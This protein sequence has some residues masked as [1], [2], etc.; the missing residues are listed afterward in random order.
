MENEKKTTETKVRGTTKSTAKK[1][2][3][4]KKDNKTVETPMET[5]VAMNEEINE[6][7]MSENQTLEQEQATP[8]GFTPE[9]MQQMFM[10]FQQMQQMS[11]Q[12]Q[13]STSVD[14][15]V[16]IKVDRN[17]KFT[18]SMLSK[19]E[20]EEVVVRS[21][22]NNRIFISPRTSIK[23]R[24]ESKGDVETLKIKEIL[25]MENTSKR[26]LHTPWLIVE[27]DRVAEALG[28]KE[29]YDMI[30][31]I[32]DIDTLIILGDEEIKNIFNKLPSEYK[33]N[34]TSQIIMMVRSRQVSD[35][36]TIDALNDVLGINLYE[37]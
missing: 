17:T 31:K 5:T 33:R 36:K 11:N 37:I 8:T 3:S 19:I 9:Q 7:E 4:K 1:N 32:E 25:T 35:L 16:D 26:F 12:V 27:D 22:V 29:M 18:K 24:W 6:V 23:Y 34:F 15:A 14:K 21:V 20:D 2:T 13:Q 28:L 30:A 10:M